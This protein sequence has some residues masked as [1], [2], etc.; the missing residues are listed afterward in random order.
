VKAFITGHNGFIGSHLIGALRI[1]GHEV[2]TPSHRLDL[3]NI[4]GLSKHFNNCDVVFHCAGFA[5]ADDDGSQEFSAQHWAINYQGAV[6]VAEAAIQSDVKRLVFISTAKAV[7]DNPAQI[8]DEQFNAPPHSAYGK[9][10]RAAEE[11]LLQLSQQSNLEVVIIR[12]VMVYGRNGKGNLPRILQGVRQGWF[13]PL[14]Q[15]GRRSIIHI[16]DLISAL[17]LAG[18]H[19]AAAGNS[20]FVADS[21]RP[22]SRDIYDA[23]RRVLKLSPRTWFIPQIFLLALAQ[24][25]NGLQKLTG[26]TLPFNRDVYDKLMQP[27]IYSSEKISR[28]LGWQPAVNLEDGIRSMIAD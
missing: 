26:R 2:V 4:E 16:D 5:H 12:P 20:Y 6:N 11:K 7:A 21:A 15:A 14:P 17:I 23:M 3:Q 18:T 22:S 27:A 28:E 8:I 9:A 24:C 1:A 25:G 13:P 19:S 10:K